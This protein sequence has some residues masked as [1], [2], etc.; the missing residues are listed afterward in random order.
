[1]KTSRPRQGSTAERVL[2]IPV[3]GYKSHLTIDRRFGFIRSFEVTNAARHEGALLRELVGSDT[4]ASDVWAD[5][6]YRSRANEAWLASR[7]RVSRLHQKKP[8]GRPM[9]E[10]TRR[11][12]ARKSAV[13]VRIEHA[14][15]HQKARMGL[16]IR[17][18][19]QTRAEAKIGL[20]NLAYN[21]QHFLFHERQL[22]TG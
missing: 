15:A 14:F 10:R 18:I 19:G 12:N 4:T 16:F 9:A 17:T 13:R 6:A 20:A 22:A 3:F 2:A 1:M 21:L 11:A 5:T 8:K 7:G